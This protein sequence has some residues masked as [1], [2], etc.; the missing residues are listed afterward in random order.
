ME[1][2]YPSCLAVMQ[3]LN[4]TASLRKE[5]LW[6]KMSN[7]TAINDDSMQDYFTNMNDMGFATRRAHLSKD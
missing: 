5:L 3:S 7:V 6:P 1:S 2:A 4:L